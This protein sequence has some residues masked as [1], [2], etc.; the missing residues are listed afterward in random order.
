MGALDPPHVALQRALADSVTS[1]VDDRV[2]PAAVH[3]VE[4]VERDP[5]RTRTPRPAAYIDVLRGIAESSGGGVYTIR[6]FPGDEG[7]R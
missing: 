7:G 5:C 4:R 1:A 2:P 3:A 6:T